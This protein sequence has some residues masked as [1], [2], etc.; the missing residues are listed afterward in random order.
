MYIFT[1][2]FLI[3]CKIC[4]ATVLMDEPTLY[5]ENTLREETCREYKYIK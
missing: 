1:Y 2:L 4:N 5:I 3:F